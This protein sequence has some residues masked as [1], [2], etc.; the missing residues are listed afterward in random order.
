MIYYKVALTKMLEQVYNFCCCDF[1]NWSCG[2]NTSNRIKLKWRT[3]QF[4]S[5]AFYK[6]KFRLEEAVFHIYKLL[7][8]QF[9]V[10]LK[11]HVCEG[12]SE[13]VLI[14]LY[15]YS[16]FDVIRFLIFQYPYNRHLLCYLVI[17]GASKAYCTV[18]KS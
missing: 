7:L 13:H 16:N 18:C 15:I 1:K 9:N 10:I 17:W 5:L 4:N 8:D 12:L 14:T 6:I 11:F 2:L 3:Y